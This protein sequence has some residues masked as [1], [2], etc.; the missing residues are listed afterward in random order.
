MW[1]ALSRQRSPRLKPSSTKVT[2][3][4]VPRQQALDITGCVNVTPK[5]LRAI[6]AACPCLKLLRLGVPAVEQVGW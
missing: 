1:P 6:A 4:L 3:L 2:P 5:T